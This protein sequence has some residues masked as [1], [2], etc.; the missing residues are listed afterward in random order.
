MISLPQAKTTATSQNWQPYLVPYFVLLPLLH[1]DGTHPASSR[2]TQA[3]LV[4]GQGY[5]LLKES[6]EL[7]SSPGLCIRGSG[8]DMIL[9]KVKWLW[10]ELFPL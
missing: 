7:L 6:V 8:Q 3:C 10:I 9:L 1:L 2:W 4:P 5:H